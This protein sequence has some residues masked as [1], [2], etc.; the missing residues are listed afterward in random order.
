MKLKRLLEGVHDKWL[1]KAILLCGGP[2]S[3]KSMVR[4]KLLP[5]FKV[6]DPDQMAELIMKREGIP[7]EQRKR[8]KEQEARRGEIDKTSYEKITG[9]RQEKFLEGKLPIVIDRTGAD[10]Y[11]VKVPKERLESLGYE[12]KMIFIDVP[13]EQA[14]GRNLARKRKLD[15]NFVRGYHRRVRA[16][17]EK[18]RSLF[19]GNFYVLDNTKSYE[20]TKSEWD[21][22]WTKIAKWMDRPVENN[23][24]NEWKQKQKGK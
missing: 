12:T 20:E 2:G 13:M 9:T 1:F 22:L 3:G 8:T 10:F 23:I 17:I 21:K 19:G 6:V 15:P 24:A 14:V 5:S 4:K 11:G 7:I 16:N 18:F